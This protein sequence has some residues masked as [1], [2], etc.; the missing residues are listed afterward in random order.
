[1]SVFYP[2]SQPLSLEHRPL[3]HPLL[4]QLRV[5][6]SEFTFANLYLFRKTRG[7]RLSTLADG[8]LAL[9]GQDRGAP[10]FML[11]FGLPEPEL[12]AVLFRDQ[13]M[14]KAASEAQQ[15]ALAAQGYR[16]EEDR[17]NFDYL[18]N[19]QDLARPG[20]RDYHKKRN[21]IKAFVSSHPAW[22]ALPLW[23]GYR[24]LALR[25]LEDWR[26]ETGQQGDYDAAREALEH[27]ELLQ[28]CGG[29]YMVEER[30]VAYVL[31]EELPGLS[32]FVIHFEKAVGGYK[33][34]YQ[35][36]NQ[37]FA[38][39]LDP[40]TFINREQDLGNPGLRQAKLSYKPVGF[41]RKFK[42]FPA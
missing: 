28:L 13:H 41:T 32:T 22:T 10:F 21:L 40:Y 11:P 6:I 24:D 42:V 30:P 18:Y 34:L 35:F 39:L 4:Q 9:L 1:M 25:V 19:R 5:G 23:P 20:G 33:G 16:V 15:A 29:L 37:S 27:M 7:Y 17:D 31:G 2:H 36:I 3:L 26:S 14:L 12:L 38:S 8:T